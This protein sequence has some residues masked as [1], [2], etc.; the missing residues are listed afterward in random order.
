MIRGGD[1]TE[2]PEEASP[3]DGACPVWMQLE[4]SKK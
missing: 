1:R 3:G 2:D 4:N